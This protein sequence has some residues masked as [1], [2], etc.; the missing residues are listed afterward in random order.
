MRR[1]R[2]ALLCLGGC[3]LAFPALAGTPATTAAPNPAPVAADKPASAAVI[4]IGDRYCPAISEGTAP[5]KT[6]K[7]MALM[8]TTCVMEASG[9]ITHEEAQGVYEQALGDIQVALSQI[10]TDDTAPVLA[11]K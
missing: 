7:I 6:Q 4:K 8:S 10:E 11:S 2:F 9:L 1:V 5:D 3:L